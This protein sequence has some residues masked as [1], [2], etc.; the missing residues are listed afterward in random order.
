ML[1]GL[2]NKNTTLDLAADVS[3][4]RPSRAR[5]ASARTPAS[6][7]ARS[8]YG[9]AP[10]PRRRRR[11]TR[12]P[13][14]VHLGDVYYAG[15]RWEVRRRFLDHRPVGLDESPRPGT[16]RPGD[17]CCSPTTSPSPGTRRARPASSRSATCW[18]SPDTSAGRAASTRGSGVTNTA[19]SPTEPA[20][21]SATRTGHG[22]VLEELAEVA[23]LG[24]AGFRETFRDTD[25]DVRRTPGCTVVDL[26]GAAA[27]VGY[28]DVD[29][30]RW[31]EP[32]RL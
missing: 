15:T 11:G 10:P 18:P 21:G 3:T 28:V 9:A 1:R 29:G 26:D 14:V 27:T 4:A 5:P 32:D 16:D 13:R 7:S 17:A 31:R 19:S 12:R 6:G 2:L 8:S 24:E 30:T 22:A 25:G 20:A 23:G